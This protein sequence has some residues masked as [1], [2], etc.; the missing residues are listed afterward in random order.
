M[1]EF[2][3]K[4]YDKQYNKLHRTMIRIN[5]SNEEKKEFEQYCAKLGVVPSTYLKQLI[6]QDAAKSGEAPIFRGVSVE[7]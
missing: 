6:N 3:K 7:E 5:V 4:E 2:C 1:G